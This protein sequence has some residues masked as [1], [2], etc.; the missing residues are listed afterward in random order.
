MRLDDG[1]IRRQSLELR[2]STLS[3]QEV[4]GMTKSDPSNLIKMLW[5]AS[6]GAMAI[7]MVISR[8]VI[9]AIYFTLLRCCV[10]RAGVSL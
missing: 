8:L 4:V 3:L 2:A 7:W 5:T 9:A 1:R 6:L 10:V